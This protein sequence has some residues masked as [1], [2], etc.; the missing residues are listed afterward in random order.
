MRFVEGQPVVRGQVLV[1]RLEL[2]DGVHDL[3]G[4][5]EDE[6]PSVE[7]PRGEG[8]EGGG[9][10]S[11]WQRRSENYTI[12]RRGVPGLPLPSHGGAW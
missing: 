1:D 2:W 7:E 9:R 5:R 6:Q 12:P 4:Q 11:R 10:H 8:A 3:A